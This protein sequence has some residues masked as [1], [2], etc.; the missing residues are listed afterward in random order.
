MRNKSAGLT[1]LGLLLGYAHACWPQPI[2]RQDCAAIFPYSD[3]G[4]NTRTLEG[5]TY[6]EA[7]DQ[8]TAPAKRSC[9]AMFSAL[10]ARC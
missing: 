3:V 10:I 4:K 6:C 7:W 2:S 5:L 1:M 9:W 8:G